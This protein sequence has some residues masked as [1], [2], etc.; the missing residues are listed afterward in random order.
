MALTECLATRLGS[1]A[2]D[3]EKENRD[4]GEGPSHGFLCLIP[5]RSMSPIPIPPPKKKPSLEK[6][7]ESLR[8]SFKKDRQRFLSGGGVP[9]LEHKLERY[10]P[11]PCIERS[12]IGYV[13]VSDV[14]KF[15]NTVVGHL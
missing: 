14:D 8:R 5:N 15:L 1:P 6:V 10:S 9:W 3:S 13:S 11:E 7:T 4:V 2:E 12:G